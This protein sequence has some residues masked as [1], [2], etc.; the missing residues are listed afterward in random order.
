M[1]LESKSSTTI[2]LQPEKGIHTNI[3]WNTFTIIFILGPTNK[4]PANKMFMKKSHFS[5]INT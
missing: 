1:P 4:F 5:Y 3:V 2:E